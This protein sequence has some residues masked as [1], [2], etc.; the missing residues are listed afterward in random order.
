MRQDTTTLDRRI[1]PFVAAIQAQTV[2]IASDPSQ[3]IHP[4][5]EWQATLPSLFPLVHATLERT[6][7]DEFGLFYIWNP[8]SK[9]LT[10]AEPVLL[11]AHYDVVDADPSDWSV[12]PWRGVIRDGSV[13]GRGTIDDKLAHIGLLQGVEELIETG[14]AP[15]RPIVLAFGGDEEVGGE[16]G[17]ARIA[18]FFQKRG[19]RFKTV[20]D[21]GAIVAEGMFPGIDKPIALI[22]CAEK[23]HINVRIT[24]SH[25][26]GHAAT[27]PRQD[28]VRS[29]AHAVAAIYR[30]RW[31]AYRTDTVSELVR[32]LGR[33]TPGVTGAVMR[34]YPLTAPIVHRAFSFRPEMD[35]MIRTTKV[36]TMLS[37]STAANVLPRVAEANFNIRLL[38]GD[39]IAETLTRLRRRVRRYPVTVELGGGWDNN[40]APRESGIDT[41]WYRGIVASIRSVWGE[42]PILPYLVTATTDSRHYEKITE[43]T[44]RFAPI[45][46]RAE[47]LMGIHGVDE[48]VS[49]ENVHRAI[50]FYRDLITRFGSYT[51]TGD[52]P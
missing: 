2:S 30:D 4:R 27:P 19:V 17:A 38:P 21:E 22:G 44:Y 8:E 31:N 26:G 3:G 46:L 51:N 5:R 11:M 25:V 9:D 29:L 41:P 6:V 7:L 49:V 43:T 47:D 52:Q 42:I 39:S 40:E 14:Y 35:A 15:E 24:A 13:W 34:L 10:N 48:H 50:E 23:G 18:E 20:F 45:Q 1:A 32:E 33:H 28:A 16:R 36:G 37:G 12:D